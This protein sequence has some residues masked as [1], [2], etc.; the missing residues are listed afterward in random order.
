MKNYILFTVIL[1]IIGLVFYSCSPGQ[2]TVETRTIY[3]QEIEV[4]GPLNE[5]PIHL[6]DSADTPSI[7]FSPKFSYNTKNTVTG[8]VSGH[9]LVNEDG[10]FEIDTIYNPDGTINHYEK[11][12]GANRYQFNENNMTWY[13]PD[14]VMS[15]DVD[16][17]ITRNFALFGGL[18]YTSTNNRGLW[19]G[20]FGLGLYGASKKGFGFRLDMGAHLQ[21][22]YYDAYTVEDVVI[23]GPSVSDNYVIFYHDTDESSHINPFINFTVNS[24]NPEWLINFFINIGYS[25]QTIIDFEPEETDDNYYDDNYFYHD[26]YREIVY[27]RRGT[28]TIGLFQ[29]TPGLTFYFGENHKLLLGTRFYFLTEFDSA[30]PKSFILPMVQVD[31][32]L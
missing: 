13:L 18:N 31:F 11:T 30:S 26:S 3:L 22:I 4:S 27:D 12:T 25:G 17:K 7:T 21:S 9:T 32:N 10:I 28:K 20:N 1:L 23:T 29:F 5:S 8:M 2:Q 19:G 15:L 24:C 14:I 16:V 6:S